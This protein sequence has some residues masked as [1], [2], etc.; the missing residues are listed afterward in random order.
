[1][2]HVSVSVDENYL[3]PRTKPIVVWP[4]VKAISSVLFNLRYLL[5]K[6]ACLI[7]NILGARSLKSSRPYDGGHSVLGHS[8]FASR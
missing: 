3:A 5:L 4:S 6:H 2:L 1:M 8:K 7:I